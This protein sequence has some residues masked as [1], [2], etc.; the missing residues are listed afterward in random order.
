VLNRARSECVRRITSDGVG[1]IDV[2][3]H[4]SR[5]PIDRIWELPQLAHFNEAL[6]TIARVVAWDHRGVGASDPLPTTVFAAAVEPRRS[7]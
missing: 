6:G 2:A 4:T 5:Y 3:L 1:P 7:A